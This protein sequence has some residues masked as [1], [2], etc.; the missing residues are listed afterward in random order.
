MT[1]A[2]RFLT[3]AEASE[4]G[5]FTPAG[6]RMTRDNWADGNA[7]ALC[8]YLDGSDDPDEA[9]DGSSL[10]DDDFLVMVNA[11]WEPL[12]FTIPPVRRGRRGGRTSTATMAGR[13]PQ[14]TRRRAAGPE[15]RSPSAPG[16]SRCCARRL[17]RARESAPGRSGRTG[18][19]WPA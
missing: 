13:P 17:P 7:L 2:G 3:G 12:D 9:P 19:C 11:W 6:A 10:L 14:P 8:A 15:I 18:C 1:P 16:P 5:W 4:L